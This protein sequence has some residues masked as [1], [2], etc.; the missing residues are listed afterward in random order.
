MRV[1]S[2][3]LWANWRNGERSALCRSC[4]ANDSW[5]EVPDHFP[6]PYFVTEA[7]FRK[8]LSPYGERS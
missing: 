8:A 1:S 4:C 5:K 6:N 3:F 2:A 7:R